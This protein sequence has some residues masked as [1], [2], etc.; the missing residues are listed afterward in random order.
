[1]VL[2]LAAQG[3]A[4]YTRVIMSSAM[5][6]ITDYHD[7]RFDELYDVLGFSGDIPEIDLTEYVLVAERVI[8][9]L[10]DSDEY[11]RYIRS[12]LSEEFKG[13]ERSGMSDGDKASY[14]LG[15]AV[16]KQSMSD[17]RAVELSRHEQLVDRSVQNIRLSRQTYGY[18]SEKSFL[19]AIMNYTEQFA[20]MY[21]T[22]T[23][24][25]L[26]KLCRHSDA[27]VRASS[28]L[29]SADILPEPRA[30]KPW[31]PYVIT[32][33]AS[34]AMVPGYR[35]QPPE[36]QQDDDGAWQL[37]KYTENDTENDEF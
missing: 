24:R 6:R 5:E 34:I 28:R 21:D 26:Y 13:L 2:L 30:K 35:I 17:P 11:R 1:V 31:L 27:A 10:S 8:P 16:W 12:S 36:D 33:L 22:P 18:G 3:L 14:L 19:I 37:P 15:A 20:D 23:R 4:E 9:T 25:H 29:K 7:R 32:A